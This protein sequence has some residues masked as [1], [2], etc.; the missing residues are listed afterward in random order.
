MFE[1]TNFSEGVPDVVVFPE[2]I[3]QISN[4]LKFCNENKIPII[5]FGVGSGFEGGINALHVILFFATFFKI[6][7]PL[8][9]L[10]LTIGWCN[11]R[12]E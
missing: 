12:Y 11:C 2:N 6:F 8:Y 3:S 5:P 4:L 9:L 7:I 10:I 1:K